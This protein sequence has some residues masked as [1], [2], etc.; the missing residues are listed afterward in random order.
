M[1]GRVWLIVFYCSNFRIIVDK[2]KLSFC[3]T[4]TGISSDEGTMLFF[5]ISVSPYVAI[6]KPIYHEL[7]LTYW[8]RVKHLCVD[9][10]GHHG[11]RYWP[12]ACLALSHSLNQC[13]HF[14]GSLPFSLLSL[15]LINLNFA[16]WCSSYKFFHCLH[17]R[18]LNILHDDCVYL[19]AE[20]LAI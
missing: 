7:Q 3:L 11:F 19:N 10:I 13:W 16:I 17:F 15:S 8:G 4:Y 14:A 18:S 2:I 1:D 9:S 12:V 20:T 6:I 5:D